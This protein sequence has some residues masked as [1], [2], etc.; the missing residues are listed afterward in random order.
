MVIFLLQDFCPQAKT[1]SELMVI[2]LIQD[3]CPQAK[4]EFVLIVIFLIQDF[5]PQAKTESVLIVHRNY[6]ILPIQWFQAHSW[7]FCRL[8]VRNLQ[9]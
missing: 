9:K 4:T 6:S 5:C 2:F 7:V 1:E 3:F 8:G